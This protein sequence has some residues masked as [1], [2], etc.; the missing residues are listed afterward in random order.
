[1]AKKCQLCIVG[2]TAMIVAET[3]VA[4]AGRPF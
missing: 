2:T 3:T 4:P 1:M